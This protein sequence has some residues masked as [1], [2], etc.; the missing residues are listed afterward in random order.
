[1]FCRNQN[2]NTLEGPT[3]VLAPIAAVADVSGSQFLLVDELV[4]RAICIL[5]PCVW[6]AKD[7]MCEHAMMLLGKTLKY[8]LVGCQPRPNNHS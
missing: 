6:C 7:E 3:A 1:M 2:M 8:S 4:C 5:K